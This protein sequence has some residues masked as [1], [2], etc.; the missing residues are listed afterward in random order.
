MMIL[1]K[2]FAD[3]SPRLTVSPHLRKL[4]D[5]FGRPISGV[6]LRL[7]RPRTAPAV[8]RY[9]TD[10]LR[11]PELSSTATLAVAIKNIR[12][13]LLTDGQQT[14]FASFEGHKELPCPGQ[15]LP[16]KAKGQVP[17]RLGDS[18]WPLLTSGFGLKG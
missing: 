6:T 11:A 12:R 2:R 14:E 7:A 18:T 15:V 1:P 4:F 17:R 9:F 10:Q 16:R 13:D 3:F 8:Y 5:T